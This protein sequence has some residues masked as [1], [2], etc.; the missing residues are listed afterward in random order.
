M[1]LHIVFLTVVSL[2]LS[3]Q[4]STVLSLD[5]GVL[6]VSPH[7]ISVYNCSDT[8]KY[9][10]FNFNLT[11]DAIVT[12]IC[13][14]WKVGFK[15]VDNSGYLLVNFS[16]FCLFDFMNNR[17]ETIYVDYTV[18]ARSELGRIFLDPYILGILSVLAVMSLIVLIL[19]FVLIRLK[20]RIKRM[21]YKKIKDV[22]KEEEVLTGN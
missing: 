14:G 1:N 15:I 11:D 16:E 2:V 10:Y 3:F 4:V 19:I 7:N 9:L 13:K 6:K 5:R 21:G 22:Q 8:D 12:Y 18:E 17:N 20:R